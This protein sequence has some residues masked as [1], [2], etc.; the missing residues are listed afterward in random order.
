M[1][2][3]FKISIDLAF[4][5]LCIEPWSKYQW[6][7]FFTLST[8]GTGLFSPCEPLNTFAPGLIQAVCAKT[9]GLHVALRGNLSGPVS[10]T[11]LVKSSKDSASLVVYTQKNFLVEEW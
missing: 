9:A 5:V 10:A 11:D 7:Y 2:Q 1:D 6:N 8:F 3:L 4:V